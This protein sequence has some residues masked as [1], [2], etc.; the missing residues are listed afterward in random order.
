MYNKIK[1][2]GWEIIFNRR[3]KVVLSETNE[4]MI[5]TL[6]NEEFALW[7]G[8]KPTTIRANKSRYLEELKEYAN[9]HIE[10]KRKVII[11]EVLE[12]I[13]VS[14]R[15]K[16]YNEI[17]QNFR[18]KYWIENLN[19]CSNVAFA[20]ESEY[21]NLS[22]TTAYN[23]VRK[24]RTELY[25]RPHRSH[26]KL[27]RCKFVWVKKLEDGS[28]EF[29][30]EAEEKIWKGLCS[31]YVGEDF[32]QEL[33]SSRDQYFKGK[34]T[35]DEFLALTLGTKK[36]FEGFI[37]KAIRKIGSKIARGTLL[38]NGLFFEEA[39]YNIDGEL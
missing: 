37:S 11:D 3:I 18:T 34:L 28:Y 36:S 38:E 25:G 23:L 21:P 31:D 22:S 9:Y 32:E 15:D 20:V 26:G 12:S 8:V 13:Y 5:G 7:R 29:F 35:K 14:N 16:I 19:S 1:C 4:L 2:I 17:I 24:A 27:G 33:I 10:G 30:N 39:V 6:T